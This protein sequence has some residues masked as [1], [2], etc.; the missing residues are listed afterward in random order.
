LQAGRDGDN[1]GGG[2]V[3]AIWGGGGR[4]KVKSQMTKAKGVALSFR[5]WKM[6]N[7]EEKKEGGGGCLRSLVGG[8]VKRRDVARWNGNTFRYKGVCGGV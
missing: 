4:G 3:E 8:G 5:K 7:K 2:G 1:K 6:G